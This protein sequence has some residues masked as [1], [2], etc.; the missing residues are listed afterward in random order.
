MTQV[1]VDDRRLPRG[2]AD[3]DEYLEIVESSCAG[4]RTRS[5]SG[6]SACSG[7]STAPTK[8]SKPLLRRFPTRVPRAQGPGENA[9]A[10]DI[11]EGWAVVFKV[12]SHQPPERDRAYREPPPASAASCATS[13]DGSPAVALLDSLRFGPL[14]A[15]RRHFEGVVAGI[16]GYGNCIG[17]PTVARGVLRDCYAGN[18]LVNA[19]CS[20]WCAPT[21]CSGRGRGHRQLA[22]LVGAQTG[23]DGIHGACLR[24]ARAGRHVRGAAAGRAG[25]QPFLEKCLL[26]ACME[27]LDRPG[28]VAIQ[29]LGAARSDQRGGRGGGARRGRGPVGRG[30][31]AAA[32]EGADAL[33]GD[34]VESRSAS[35]VVERGREARLAEVFAKWDLRRR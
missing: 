12:E 13:S 34:A 17:V 4:S 30:V 21:G 24:V 16:G 26:E 20:A 18:P 9:R 31:R 3:Q 29:D 28:V 10:V 22:P 7:P 19:M 15:S 8:T 32:R 25:G 1:A 33:R 6:C 27:L 11:G 35:L 5:S 14:P 2:R 23:L